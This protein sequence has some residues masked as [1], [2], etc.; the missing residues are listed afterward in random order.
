[1]SNPTIDSLIQGTVSE[2]KF[3]VNND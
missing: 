1:M 3:R 2:L